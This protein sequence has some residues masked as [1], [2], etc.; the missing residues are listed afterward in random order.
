MPQK[1]SGREFG[2]FAREKLLHNLEQE[3][4]NYEQ[5]AGVSFFKFNNGTKALTLYSSL[6]DNVWFYGVSKQYWENWDDNTH[7]FFLLG[8]GSR[9]DYLHLNPKE[10][11]KLLE[12][13]NPAGDKQKK[14]NIRMPT[15]GKIYF[16]EWSSFP[17]AQRIINL[18][19]I[20]IK[21]GKLKSIV[22]RKKSDPTDEF[23]RAWKSLTE[24]KRKE[25]LKEIEKGLLE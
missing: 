23:K 1:V 18:G 7:M 24:Q 17:I 2:K 21:N 3:W 10:S 4:G 5:L 13:I 8:D 12:K 20:E 9:C 25:L 15:I 19:T 16:S 22:K 11:I 6:N 14:I